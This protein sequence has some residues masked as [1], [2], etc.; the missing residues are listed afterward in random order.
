M[1]RELLKDSKTFATPIILFLIQDLGDAALT[2]EP[3]T[4]ADRLRM[5]EPE[6][7]QEVIDRTNAAL[8]LFTSNLFWTDPV[9]FGVVCRS[10]NRRKFPLSGEPTIGDICWGVTEAGL[11]TTDTVDKAAP[12]VFSESIIKYVMYTLKNNGL[13]SSPSALKASFG[14]VPFTYVV[15]DPA[16]AEARQTEFDEAAAELDALV[17][18]KMHQLLLQIKKSGVKLSD[19]A[20]RDVDELLY[21]AQANDQNTQRN[22]I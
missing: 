6:V 7:E 12:E 11:L 2:Y 19:S 16:I 17:S 9:I 13:Y 1:I 8:G 10:L 14:E 4:I 18:K 22:N 5:I 3:E 20:S 15:D 21:G